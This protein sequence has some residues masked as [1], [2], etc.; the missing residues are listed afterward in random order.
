MLQEDFGLW[1]TR[2][3]ARL[4][5]SQKDLAVK[6]KTTQPWVSQLVT[7]RRKR[8]N[9]EMVAR[10]KTALVEALKARGVEDEDLIMKEIDDRLGAF[11]PPGPMP[12]DQITEVMLVI[13]E[14]TE[15]LI[16]RYP[17]KKMRDKIVR[18]LKS[19]IEEF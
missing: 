4:N 1:L 19:T 8:A 17:S 5:L 12:E 15:I 6:S 16:E 3:L 9:P 7:G 11:V 10:L 13:G 14:L 18:L 2:L